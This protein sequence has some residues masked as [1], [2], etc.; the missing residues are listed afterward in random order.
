[1]AFIWNPETLEYEYVPRTEDDPSIGFGGLPSQFPEAIKEFLQ[2]ELGPQTQFDI[3][4]GRMFPEFRD[5]PYLSS[6]LGRVQNPLYGQFLT[7]LY[8]DDPFAAGITEE[9]QPTFAE[10]LTG[11][12]IAGRPED[13]SGTMRLLDVP[14]GVP[15]NWGD[16]VRTARAGSYQPNPNIYGVPGLSSLPMTGMPGGPTARAYDTWFDILKKE[17][18][19][20]SL[21]RMATFDPQSRGILGRLRAQGMERARQRWL[22]ENAPGSQRQWADWLGYITSPGVSG[23]VRPEWKIGFGL[24]DEPG[25][26]P[27]EEYGDPQNPM[28]G[29]TYPEGYGGLG[30]FI[31]PD[32]VPNPS[33]YPNQGEEYGDPQ[34]PTTGMTYPEGYGGLGPFTVNQATPGITGGVDSWFDPNTRYTWN[35]Q[36]N[37][38]TGGPFTTGPLGEGSQWIPYKETEVPGQRDQVVNLNTWFPTGYTPQSIY[39]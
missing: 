17:G 10:W 1:M 34:D 19:A 4:S 31:A 27:S 28:T 3:A 36:R 26:G 25:P 20:E 32:D 11:Q 22:A 2:P 13:P 18:Q 24:G 35:L 16:I 12:Q 9:Q 14:T 5:S 39:G 6:Y 37:P 29:M 38:I 30:P 21:A 23:Y 8:S 7:N 15:E 33:A